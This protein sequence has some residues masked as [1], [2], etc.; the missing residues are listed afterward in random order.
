[1]GGRA[2]YHRVGLLSRRQVTWVSMRHGACYQ[3]RVCVSV[4]KFLGRCGGGA[5]S[6]VL[7]WLLG[8]RRNCDKV[9]SLRVAK[10]GM[11]CVG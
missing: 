6:K 5:Q 10:N 2:A 11:N 4:A 7:C 8:S 9:V 1:M 3:L